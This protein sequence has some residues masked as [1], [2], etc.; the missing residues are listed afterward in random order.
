MGDRLFVPGGRIFSVKF[1][2]GLVALEGFGI[3][4]EV[5]V[6]NCLVVPAV[7]ILG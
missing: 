6:D 7:S 5:E 3:L 1:D 2:A 4:L